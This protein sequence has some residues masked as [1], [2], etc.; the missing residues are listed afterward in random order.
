M[1]TEVG[2]RCSEVSPHA[3]RARSA[4]KSDHSCSNHIQR[5][6]GKGPSQLSGHREPERWFVLI[7]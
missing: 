5:S 3:E 2:E 6:R 7:S 4:H 1:R